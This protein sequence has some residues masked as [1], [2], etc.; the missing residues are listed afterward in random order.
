[1]IANAVSGR[2][3][4]AFVSEEVLTE[5]GAVV[6]KERETALVS[7]PEFAESDDLVSGGLRGGFLFPRSRAG[8][9]GTFTAGR[10]LRTTF[11]VTCPCGLLRDLDRGSRSAPEMAKRAL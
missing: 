4:K 8:L 11:A 1:M 9:C 3:E 10:S 5:A 6:A 2:S 7:C